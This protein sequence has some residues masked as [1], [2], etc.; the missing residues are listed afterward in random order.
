MDSENFSKVEISGNITSIS[1]VTFPIDIL[2]IIIFLV[3]DDVPSLYLTCKIFR[4]VISS[5]TEIKLTKPIL[6]HILTFFTRARVIDVPII[7]PFSFVPRHHVLSLV[8]KLDGK[9]FICSKFGGVGHIIKRFN[10]E[11]M[12]TYINYVIDEYS[13]NINCCIT[14]YIE[15]YYFMRRSRNIITNIPLK[16]IEK[17]SIYNDILV[18]EA[19]FDILQIYRLARKERTIVISNK[20]VDEI[21]IDI[22]KILIL[23]K[24]DPRGKRYIK[25]QISSKCD[26]KDSQYNKINCNYIHIF[27]NYMMCYFHQNITECECK[28]NIFEIKIERIEV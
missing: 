26:L 19:E 13:R 23:H 20:I 15:K 3:I 2:K 18:E 28:G 14:I 9:M 25:L 10:F 1:D 12:I 16:Y 21:V 5:I 27:A 17:I 4:R 22:D 11:Y 24:K 8:L 7:N 6:G